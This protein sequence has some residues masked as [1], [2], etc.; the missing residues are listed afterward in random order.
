MLSFRHVLVVASVV[1][2]VGCGG[3][4]VP[5]EP[6]PR[7][8]IRVEP[9]AAEY[10]RGSIAQLDFVND[11]SVAASS[12]ACAKGL[13]RLVGGDAWGRLPSYEGSC[14]SVMVTVQPG[15]RK[16]LSAIL[17]TTLEPGTYRTYHEL[18][19]GVLRIAYVRYSEPFLVR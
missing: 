18:S 14:F 6:A 16:R 7:Q 8:A 4:R 11:S 1:T 19:I 5:S 10:G 15:E 3:S 17:P 9:L 12:S 13:E 2:A